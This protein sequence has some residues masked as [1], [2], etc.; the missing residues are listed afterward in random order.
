MRPADTAPSHSRA[1]RGFNLV[2]AAIVLG[3]VGLVIGGIWTAA[4][5]VRQKTLINQAVMGMLQIVEKY[6]SLY[7]PFG[8]TSIP[9]GSSSLNTR[10]I[11]PVPAGYTLLA[12]GSLV[13]P[14][15]NNM[16]GIGTY[17][18][19]IILDLAQM[20]FSFNNISKASCIEMI[21]RLN[22]SPLVYTVGIGG[23]GTY[24]MPLPLSV[25]DSIICVS[26]NINFS[27]YLFK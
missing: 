4:S 13:D 12:N 19:G 2:E 24:N 22:L 9:D 23:G 11:D 20:G 27:F 26:P 15:G 16:G 8:L 18:Q 25:A 10:I 21:T 7:A 3:V 17:R 5:A 1:R 6:R 14:W